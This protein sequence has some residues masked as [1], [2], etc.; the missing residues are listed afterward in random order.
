MLLMPRRE[1][2]VNCIVALLNEFGLLLLRFGRRDGLMDCE[3]DVSPARY[4][5]CARE[6]FKRSVDGD[7]DYRQ[8]KFSGEHERS[9][10]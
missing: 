4:F 6:H 1:C 8:P 2:G 5:A 3:C 7:G 9:A 10:L